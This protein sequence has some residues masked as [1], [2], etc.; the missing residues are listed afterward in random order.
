MSKNNKYDVRPTVENKGLVVRAKIGEGCT[1]DSLKEHLAEV[2]RATKAHLAVMANYE[3]RDQ[4]AKTQNGFPVVGPNSGD[5]NTVL[6][7]AHNSAM[8]VLDAKLAELDAKV[9]VVLAALRS[10]NR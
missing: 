6:A 1:A 7:K 3:E 10:A 5:F 9:A 8:A 4:L 2:E